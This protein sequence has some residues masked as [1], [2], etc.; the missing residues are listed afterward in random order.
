MHRIFKAGALALVLLIASHTSLA[1]WEFDPS[2][3]VAVDFDDNAGLNTRTDQEDD[4]SGYIGEVDLEMLYRSE[5]S[6]LSIQP[7]LR[8]RAYDSEI[9][10]DSDDQ[11]LNLR[12]RRDGEASALGFRASYGRESVRTA[13]L[14]DAG[15]DTDLD[16]D[17]IDDDETGRVDTRDRRERFRVV[18]YWTYRFSN[19]SSIRADVGYLDVRYES[20]DPD[21]TS[22]L[23]DFTD[24][25]GNL[26]YQRAL[27]A[28]NTGVIRLTARNYQTE[29]TVGGDI[30]GYGVSLGLNREL[31]ETTTLRALIGVEETETFIGSNE[32]NWVGDFSIVRRQQTT[33]LLAQYRQR[34][35]ASGRGFLVKRNEVNLR[36]MRDLN[37][38]F[39][40][41]LGA[42]AYQ[43]DTLADVTLETNYVQLHGQLLWQLSNAFSIRANYR[44]TV[45]ERSRDGEG[46][47]S[48]RFTLWFTY[49]PNSRSRLS[50]QEQ[51]NL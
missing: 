46:A 3:R 5:I 30:S 19:V 42:R 24:I 28:R 34:I 44:Y 8:T 22:N 32:P 2:V 43:T 20:V 4:I 26:S 41:G 16:P 14:A 7:I 10:R 31:T 45:L 15:L 17:E 47:N 50:F 51:G 27:S 13:E 38:R 18:P 25:R 48:N 40:A 39:S 49:Q 6:T 37:D 35:S 33:Q 1:E 11:F 12:G 29:R 36:F 9:D 23:V 21:L